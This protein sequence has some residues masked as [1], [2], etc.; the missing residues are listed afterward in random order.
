MDNLLTFLLIGLAA[1]FI[2]RRM[3]PPKGVKQMS[4]SELNK[5][6]KLNKKTNN[7]LM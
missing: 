1:L 3:I 7:L 4:A 5:E 2:L 6:L